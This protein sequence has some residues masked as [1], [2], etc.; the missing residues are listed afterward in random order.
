M[1]E[2][3]KRETPSRR[4]TVLPLEGLAKEAGKRGTKKISR[5]AR[6]DSVGNE[7]PDDSVGNGYPDDSAGKM[8]TCGI[9]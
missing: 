1:S 3:E 8:D 9:V 7:Y 5:C 2:K 4:R 6:N